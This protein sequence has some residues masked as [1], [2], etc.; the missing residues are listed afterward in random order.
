MLQVGDTVVDRQTVW[1]SMLAG[2]SATAGG[3]SK[4][5]ICSPAPFEAPVTTTTLCGSI[6][7]DAVHAISGAPA[8]YR[9]A[10]WQQ[11]TTYIAR[12]D[13]QANNMPGLRS[14]LARGQCI[15]HDR[16]T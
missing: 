16:F 6:L 8:G 7:S 13:G 4:Q 1:H 2:A 12:D 9:I 10:H 11:A 14:P 15:K 5:S 3:D